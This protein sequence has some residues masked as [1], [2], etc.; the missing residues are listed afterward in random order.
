MTIRLIDLDAFD[1]ATPR[2]MDQ[3][4]AAV[5][6]TCRET[7]FLQVTGHGIPDSL[8]REMRGAVRA[9]FDLPQEDKDRVAARDGAPYGYIGTGQEAL[10]K[11]RGEDTP[12]DLKETFNG[13]P[14]TVPDGETDPDAP[15]FC[16]APTPYPDLPGFE[17]AWTAYYAEMEALAARIMGVMAL[18]LGQPRDFF[19]PFIDAP[20]SALRALNYPASAQPAASGQFG[21]GA[22]TDYGS[23]TILLPDRNSKGLEIQMPDGNWQEV[24][25]RDGAFVVNIGDLMALWTGGRWRSTLHRVIHRPARRGSI[26]YFHQPNWHAQISPLDG[27]GETVTSGPYL[28]SKFAAATA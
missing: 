11:S 17:R 18:A 12:P 2:E 24:E 4:A 16:Y 7:G 25:P 3:L 26:A 19:E 10:A 22:H 21:A 8:I 5:D 27:G 1:F 9:F 6:A 20:V 28:M 13:G 15:A 14:L 23:L